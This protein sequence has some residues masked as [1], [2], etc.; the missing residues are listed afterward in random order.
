MTGFAIEAHWPDQVPAD[1]MDEAVDRST[2]AE[3]VVKA[4]VQF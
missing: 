3:V 2:V 1:E 4:E